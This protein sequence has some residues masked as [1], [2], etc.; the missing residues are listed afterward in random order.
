[1][2]APEEEKAPEI[3]HFIAHV[4]VPSQKEVRL[5]YLCLYTCRKQWLNLQSLKVSSRSLKELSRVTCILSSG[6]FTY[7]VPGVDILY[8][9][10]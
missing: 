9:K 3:E 2:K 5:Y 1:M 6:T 7:N 8:I 4:P 10:C